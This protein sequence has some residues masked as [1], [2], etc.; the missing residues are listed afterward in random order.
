MTD[1]SDRQKAEDNLK[2]IVG[3]LDHGKH[4]RRRRRVRA[5]AA[6]LALG[7]GVAVLPWRLAEANRFFAAVFQPL[8]VRQIPNTSG[9]TIRRSA[10]PADKQQPA[11]HSLTIVLD[12]ARDES[13]PLNQPSLPELVDRKKSLTP[14]R[15]PWHAKRAFRRRAPQVQLAS[16]GEPATTGI[17]PE[18]FAAPDGVTPAKRGDRKLL[19]RESRLDADDA[20][21]ALRG[22]Q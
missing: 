8:V 14:A 2:A 17:G 7:L 21:R 11:M 16:L 3:W 10:R 15:R 9:D 19:Q 18:A 5:M 4:D 13:A 6:V 1:N 22:K 20:I 12:R